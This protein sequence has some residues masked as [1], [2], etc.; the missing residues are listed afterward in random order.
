MHATDT[1]NAKHNFEQHA[2]ELGVVVDSCHTDNGVYKSQ[3]FTEE[4]TNNHQSIRFSGVGAK[5][6]NGVAEGA[7]NLV[8]SK[9]RTM[10]IHANLHWP[11]AKDDSLWPMVLS[12]AT[13]L[14]LQ[15]H[16]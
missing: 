7:T 3:A 11:E 8:V 14:H 4:L 15:Q 16:S 13:N 12:D 2:M 9:A 1:I 5:W 10:M 6:Q